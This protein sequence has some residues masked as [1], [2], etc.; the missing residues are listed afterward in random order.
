MISGMYDEVQ[1]GGWGY[2]RG[3]PERRNKKIGD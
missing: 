1:Q 2:P 3:Y